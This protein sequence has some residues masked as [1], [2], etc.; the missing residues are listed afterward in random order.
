MIRQRTAVLRALLLLVA[1][2]ANAARADDQGQASVF[3]EGDFWK[4]KVVEKPV[5][6]FSST[7]IQYPNGIFTL[8]YTA[9]GRMR[10]QEFVENKETPLEPGQYR[11]RILSLLGLRQPAG[12]TTTFNILLPFPFYVGKQWRYSY[13]P[14]IFRNTFHNTVNSE[15]VAEQQ[16][17]TQAGNFRAL[18]IEQTQQAALSYNPSGRSF[19]AITRGAYY[20]SPETK[21]IVKYDLVGDN[22]DELHIELLEFAPAH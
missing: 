19:M 11:R 8:R 13:K 18:R 5:P 17:A 20:Y 6:G 7:A 12:S 14:T 1:L 3:K 9:R 15:V 22:G 16:V 4:F 21:S 10:V 2:V